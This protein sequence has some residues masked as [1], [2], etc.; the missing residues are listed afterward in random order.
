MQLAF[1][2]KHNII[3]WQ[4]ITRFFFNA[5]CMKYMLISPHITANEF[6][7]LN[8]SRSLYKDFIEEYPTQAVTVATVKTKWMSF[9]KKK[10]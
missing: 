1:D 5:M 6:N 8:N 4:Q 9:F 7:R 10:K 3:K 2:I